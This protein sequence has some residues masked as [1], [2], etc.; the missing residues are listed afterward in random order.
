MLSRLPQAFARLA[1]LVQQGGA[2]DIR[3]KLDSP[4]RL[5]IESDWLWTVR[6][7]TFD[8]TRRAV[9]IGPR[10]ERVLVRFSQIHSVDVRTLRAD[11]GS[12]AGYAIALHRGWFDNLHLGSTCDDA[13]ASIVAARVSTITGVKVLSL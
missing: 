5:V 4:A 6:T 9:L 12:A 10:G 1:Q 13:H 8:A 2:G 7:Y 3:I 11:N